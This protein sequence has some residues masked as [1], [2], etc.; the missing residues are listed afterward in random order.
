M[1][2][3]RGRYGAQGIALAISLSSAVYALTLLVLLAR[4][5]TASAR[6]ALL[7]RV[8]AVAIGALGMHMFLTSAIRLQMSAWIPWRGGMLVPILCGVSAYVAWLG[9]YRTRLRFVRG[10]IRA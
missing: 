10:Y 5:F 2:I 4:E 9:L 6:G 8:A 3:L 7:E 1:W